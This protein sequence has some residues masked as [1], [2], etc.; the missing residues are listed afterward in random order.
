MSG[1]LTYKHKLCGI[2]ATFT[3]L[4]CGALIFGKG[5]PDIYGLI[6]GF[7]IIIPASACAGFGG[8]LT[9][10]IFDSG[11]SSSGSSGQIFK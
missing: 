6:S 1:K 5:M 3:A 8:Y 7:G 10:K 11:N 2:F 4:L 9:G